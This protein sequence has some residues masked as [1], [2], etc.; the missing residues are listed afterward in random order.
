M[1]T[2][3]WV[4]IGSGNGLLPDGTKPLTKPML[5]FQHKGPVMLIWR[6]ISL[7]ISQPSIIKISLKIIFLRFYW[8][9]P[10]ANELKSKFQKGLLHP[11]DAFLNEHSITDGTDGQIPSAVGPIY[12][13]IMACGPLG[14]IGARAP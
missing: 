12:I 13:R 1:A 4:N 2:E 7:E 5:T 9:L 10:G 3:I 14:P 6:A 8:N 11:E